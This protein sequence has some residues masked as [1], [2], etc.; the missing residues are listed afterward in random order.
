MLELT[1]LTV[2]ECPNGAIMLELLAG[3]LA[4][5]PDARL[6]RRV[7]KDE[8]DAVRLGMHGSPTLLVNGVDPFAAPGTPA[9]VSCRIYRDRAGRSAG[10]PSAGALRLALARAASGDA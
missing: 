6:A 2:P 8:A 4:E 5:H 9:S 1:V 10:S 3:F 7:V